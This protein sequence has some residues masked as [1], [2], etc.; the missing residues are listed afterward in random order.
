MVG[1]DATAGELQTR[2]SRPSMEIRRGDHPTRSG[3]GSVEVVITSS[4]YET[5][6]R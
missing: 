2:N 1:N 4:G 3:R 6:R 5:H